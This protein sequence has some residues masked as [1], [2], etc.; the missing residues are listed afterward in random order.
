MAI[1]EY[2]LFPMLCSMSIDECSMF[3]GGAKTKQKKY[4]NKDHRNNDDDNE[5]DN[6]K[7]LFVQF[8]HKEHLNLLF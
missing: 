6:N 1:I 7:K 2:I 8:Q 5:N 4:N 3:T